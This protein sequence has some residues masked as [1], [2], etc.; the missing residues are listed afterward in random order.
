MSRNSEDIEAE[1]LCK[2]IQSHMTGNGGARGQAQPGPESPA[3]QAK[4][5]Y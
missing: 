1:K 4:L 2:L 3:H 5:P